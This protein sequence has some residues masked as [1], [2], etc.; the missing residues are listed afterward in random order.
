[1]ALIFAIR[2]VGLRGNRFGLTS[3]DVQ[4]MIIME[5]TNTCIGEEMRNH[6]FGW[7]L[8]GTLLIACRSKEG[9]TASAAPDTDKND[10]AVEDSGAAPDT[11]GV[12]SSSTFTVALQ[13]DEV[14]GQAQTHSDWNAPN[15]EIVDLK[16]D[17]YV[18]DNDSTHRPLVVFT[19]GGGWSGGD[20]A[21]EN[22]T[23]LCNFFAER[24]FVCASINYRLRRNRGTVPIAYFDA[25]TANENGSD[26]E[27]QQALAMY[28]AGRDCKAA[29][30]WLVAN[31]S[32]IG[33]DVDAISLMGAS[34]GSFNSIAMDVTGPEAYRDELTLE[35]DPTLAS[36]NTEIQYDIQ[37][38]VNYWGGASMVRILDEVYGRDSFDS[39]DAPLLILHGTED[40]VVPFAKAEELVDIYTSIGVHNELVSLEGQG[41]GVWGATVEGQSLEE[42]SFDFITEQLGL[43]VVE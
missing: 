17:L 8:T 39:T 42:I 43:T 10:T 27:R 31:A 15:P 34:A 11:N 32:E 5:T 41:H 3:K 29:V 40:D 30:R 21:N 18:P 6:I 1:M 28:P 24:G 19:H 13:S 25:I 7:L 9:D 4:S 22:E 38:V 2:Y 12:Y 14:Y 26:A 35:E 33:I 36:I 20:K 16:L 37:A 23:E